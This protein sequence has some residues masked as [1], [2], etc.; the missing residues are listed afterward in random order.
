M[1]DRSLIATVEIRSDIYTSCE[2]LHSKYRKCVTYTN[3]VNG[4]KVCGEWCAVWKR[5]IPE[6]IRFGNITNLEAYGPRE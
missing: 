6:V 1:N 2:L 3:I 5:D 4:S